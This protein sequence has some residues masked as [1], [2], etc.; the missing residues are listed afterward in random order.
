[1][2]KPTVFFLFAMAPL[3]ATAATPWTKWFGGYVRIEDD[4]NLACARYGQSRHCNWAATVRPTDTAGSLA[5]GEQMQTLWGFTGYD[6]PEHWCNQAYADLYANWKLGNYFGFNVYLAENPAGDLLCESRDALHCRWN[7]PLTAPPPQRPIDPLVC[8]KA[9]A[10]QWVADTKAPEHWCNQARVV[11]DERDYANPRWAKESFSYESGWAG[12]GFGLSGSQRGAP[13]SIR[14][15]TKD[16]HTGLAIKSLPRDAHWLQ[17]HPS[18]PYSTAD[19]ELQDDLFFYAKRSWQAADEPVLV[20]H[21]Y[22]PTGTTT[23]LRMPVIYHRAGVEERAWPGIW[24]RPGGIRLRTVRGDYYVQDEALNRGA[25]RWWT[26]GLKVT[27]SGDVEF[28]AASDW[29]AS[30]F[31]PGLLRG[32]QSLLLRSTAYNLIRQADATAMISNVLA[33]QAEVVIGDIRYGM[34]TRGQKQQQP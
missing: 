1:M 29:R 24:L 5:C 14:I 4:G 18:G 19:S 27:N 8:G 3:L 11:V 28:Y 26:L 25:G 9:M 12:K 17:Q 30:P 31:E 33:K 20:M 32:K 34:K 22:R 6:Q 16:G 23:S 10:A 15:T 21:V 2:N 7:Q 13:E